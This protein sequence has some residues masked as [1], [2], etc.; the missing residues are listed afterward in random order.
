M[1]HEDPIVLTATTMREWPLPAPDA[2]GDKN[3]RGSVLIV[4][5]ALETPGALLLAAASA[6]RSGVGR[7][8]L[9]TC[10]S[11]AVPAGIAMPE[12]RVFGLPETEAGDIAPEA[13]DKLAELAS[14]IDAVLL[15]P[16][17]L[18]EEAIRQLL[19]RLLPRITPPALVLD[20]G[21]L[22]AAGPEL[23]RQYRSGL[24]LT[25]HAGE[26]A[27]LGGT[28]KDEVRADPRAIALRVAADLGAV[29]ALKGPATWIASGE[30]RLYHYSGGQVGLATSGSGDTLSGIV[31]GLAARGTPALQAAA[32]GVFL[33][34]EAGNR[35]ARRIGPLGFFARELPDEVPAIMAE[36]SSARRASRL[37]RP[38]PPASGHW[39]RAARR[40]S[41]GR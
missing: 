19:E 5:G 15:G 27:R 24:I 17:M 21:A 1:H 4:G 9:A 3:E 2:Q 7:L 22:T 34:G 14:G 12:A 32:W 39:L 25:P 23:L 10:R 31:A 35:L 20:A 8:R 13:A 26:M 18:D 29:V 28:T 30:G 33:H 6:L 38:P 36:L 40:R 16:G 37:L 11:I 41:P